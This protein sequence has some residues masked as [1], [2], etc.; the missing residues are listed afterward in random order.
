MRNNEY[1]LKYVRNPIH[2]KNEEAFKRTAKFNNFY[3]V[4][5]ERQMQ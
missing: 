5:T 1:V 2:E 3:M 4:M